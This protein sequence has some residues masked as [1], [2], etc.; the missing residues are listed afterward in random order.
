M[1][2]V[3]F[4]KMYMSILAA[5][6]VLITT[7]AT[8]FA[9]VGMLSTA[10]LG[11]FTMNLKIEDFDSPYFLTIS[12][13]DGTSRTD[14][15]SSTAQ[16]DI[17]KQILDNM[18]IDYSMIDSTSTSEMN[19]YFNL[20][21]RLTP[22]TTDKNL[23][24]FYAMTYLNQKSTKLY[25]SKS[26]YKFDV[27]LSVDEVEGITD[28]TRINAPVFL[29]NIKDCITG[30]LSS[31]T[32][33]GGNQ[34]AGSSYN[35]STIYDPSSILPTFNSSLTIDSASAARIAFQIYDPIALKDN[36]S[37]SDT[38]SKTVIYQGGTKVPSY[39]NGV[40]SFG[41]ILPEEYNLAIK[42]LNAIYD[43]KDDKR[44][45]LK[46]AKL[47]SNNSEYLGAYYRTHNNLDVYND[48]DLE[49]IDDLEHKTLWAKPTVSGINY[50]G[51]Q[52]IGDE[53]IQ[54]KMKITVYFWFEGFD[55]DCFQFIDH[56]N[57]DINLTFATDKGE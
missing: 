24:E 40:Y 38:P 14:F 46:N 22:V 39:E 42:E 34:F 18:D 41:G 52:K 10:T 28:S 50:L 35:P 20:A 54:T 2:S 48:T 33:I 3:V 16:L 26:Y 56:K 13:Y 49:L 55:A 36:Y 19:K 53:V 31:G 12:S 37:A 32:L 57:V 43:L 6:L 51:V 11:G 5:M 29:E 1:R 15:G 25:E 17:Q 44:L 23:S 47:A 7:V 30:T 21:A 4:R 9:W 8:T 27:Y 45:T